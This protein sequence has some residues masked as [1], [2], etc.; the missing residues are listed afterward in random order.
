MGE[1]TAVTSGRDGCCTDGGYLRGARGFACTY[2]APR[3]HA[4][5]VAN[6]IRV[7]R[8]RVARLMRQAGVAGVSRR[9]FVTTTVRG[10]RRQAPD[11]VDRDFTAEGPDRLWVADISVPQQAA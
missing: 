6:G 7:G 8:K 3:I 9:R 5:L 2:G 4:E 10:D 11:L 1:A